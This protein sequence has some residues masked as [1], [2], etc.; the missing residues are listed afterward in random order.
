MIHGLVHDAFAAVQIVAFR[1]DMAPQVILLMG[2]PAAGKSTFIKKEMSKYY[3]HRMP[4]GGAFQTVSSDG[5]VHGMQFQRAKRDFAALRGLSPGDWAKKTSEMK[6]RA[7]DGQEIQFPLGQDQ[8][9]KMDFKAYWAATYRPYYASYFGERAEAMKIA[10]EMLDQKIKSGDVVIFDATGTKVGKYLG[11]FKKA[12]AL[13]YTTS[14]IWLDIPTEFCIARDKY[15][16]ETEGRSVGQQAI[17]G[18]EPQLPVAYQQYLASDLVDRILHFRWDG[19]VIKGRYNLVQDLKRYPRKR[20]A[21][22]MA[23]KV[24]PDLDVEPKGDCFRWTIQKVR[25]DQL[26]MDNRGAVV[27]GVV[28]PVGT[29][30]KFP[31]AWVEIG[32]KV[33]DWQNSAVGDYPGGVD[34]AKFYRVMRPTKIQRYTPED[35]MILSIRNRHY[36]PWEK[37]KGDQTAIEHKGK[38]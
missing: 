1:E 11:A 5:Q 35:A 9:S 14:V 17:L 28:A 10:D 3:N 16:G 32:N 30:K 2:L 19:G 22:R 37:S 29:N 6:Y 21:L 24:E 25:D 23:A 13:D 38:A 34:K 36:G 20:E 8:F 33:F 27:H 15:R 4:H 18:Y 31:H 26:F 7:N 12:K